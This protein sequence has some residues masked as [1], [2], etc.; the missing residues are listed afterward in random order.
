MDIDYDAIR[1]ARDWRY[2]HLTTPREDG[3]L[4]R[5][6]WY[7][8]P[9]ADDRTKHASEVRHYG[10]HID[11]LSEEEIAVA[12]GVKSRQELWEYFELHNPDIVFTFLGD[13]SFGIYGKADPQA[14]APSR[15]RST[16][17]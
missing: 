14:K 8:F 5:V 13:R 3:D 17:G 6:W 12:I 16:D 9:T 10:G 15:E 11:L 1:Y 2:G 4:E 7:A